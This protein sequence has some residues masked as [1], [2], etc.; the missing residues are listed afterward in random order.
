MSI[1]F[2]LLFGIVS[3]II[4]SSKGFSSI[5]WFLAL[6]IIGLIVV[7]TLPSAKEE[8]LTEEE[9]EARINRANKIGG[10]MT[11]INIG[12]S[13]VIFFIAIALQ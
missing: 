4:A 3:M 2:L 13:I 9:V 8:S 5:R 12:L 11:A 7:S 10:T 6:G 1:I